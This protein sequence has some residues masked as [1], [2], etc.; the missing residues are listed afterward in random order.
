MKKESRS[1][2][3]AIT[4]LFAAHPHTLNPPLP[5]THTPGADSSASGYL[6]VHLSVPREA[7]AESAQDAFRA[8]VNICVRAL[9]KK[10]NGGTSWLHCKLR[11]AMA[12]PPDECKVDAELQRDGTLVPLPQAS[13]RA[14]LLGNSNS[15]GALP[16]SSVVMA[17]PSPTLAPSAVAEPVSSAQYASAAMA[18]AAA[19]G[20][21]PT[22]P[23]TPMSPMTPT[24]A[25]PESLA[26]LL[27]QPGMLATVCVCIEE[28]G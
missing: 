21:Y 20:G 7:L 14:E 4:T 26:R 10:T 11:G 25:R 15:A 22:S 18:A 9:A 23:M 24:R 2:H 5:P 8:K 1:G 19:A 16:S 17:T 13:I 12:L 6:E 28:G 3:Q 27:Q